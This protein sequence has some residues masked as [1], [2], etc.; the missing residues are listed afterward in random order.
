MNLAQAIEKETNKT[1]TENGMKAYKST[2]NSCVDL[3]S[4][5][6][7]MRGKDVIPSFAKALAE[8]Q[9]KAVRI[10]LWARD[11]RG[12]AG[13]RK[14]FRDALVYLAQNDY[15]QALKLIPK[16][17]E[18][19]R[20]DDL[21]VLLNTP[22]ERE[23]VEAIRT[24]LLAG[25]GLVAK[26][27]PRKGPIADRLRKLLEWTPK[28]YRKTLVTLTSVVEQQMCAGKWNEINYN[29]VPSVASARYQKAFGRHNQEGYAAYLASLQKGDAKINANAV[30][31]Y[32]V[33]KSLTRGNSA[34][35]D[36]QWKS[37][38]NYVPEGVDILPVVD[39][40]G[41]MNAPAGGSSTVRCV[42]VAISLGLYLSERLTGVWKDKFITFSERPELCYTTGSLSDRYMQMSGANWGYNTN[43]EAVFKLILDVATKFKLDQSNIPQKVVVFSDMQFDAASGKKQDA[44]KM[45]KKM[46]KEHG[47]KAPEMIFWNLNDK[48]NS[49]TT[50]DKEGVC[51]VSGF[52]PAIMKT[53]LSGKI[54]TPEDMMNEVIMQE[55]YSWM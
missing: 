1:T 8:D 45:V 5:V 42:D 38:P 46:F 52:S 35:A 6:G 34:V 15:A 55:R 21:L 53:V 11:I 37:L 25:N 41:S 24:A 32:D 44:Y 36:Q 29:H 9:D 50:F 7:A 17:P 18:L 2:L 43:F 22:C 33:L 47:Y 27:M 48:G 3:F 12:G 26:W 4:S 31:P 19:G 13:E 40:S 51:M 16:T 49:P 23:A 28:F 10:M 39:V 30:Y 14:L 54:I 20:W